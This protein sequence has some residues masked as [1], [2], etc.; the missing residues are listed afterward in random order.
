MA[1]SF[2]EKL[3]QKTN[4]HLLS[5]GLGAGEHTGFID[6]GSYALNL[7]ACG[8][9]W[10]GIPNNS[11]VCLA[12]ETS[13]GKTYFTLGII[14]NFLN[15]HPDAGVFY[16]D[17][18]AAV[19]LKMAEN[20][21]IDAERIQIFGPKS[22][23]SFRTKTIE[24]IVKYQELCKEVGET[25]PFMMVLDSLGNLSSEKELEDTAAFGDTKTAE[26]QRNT[27]DM[28]KAGLLKGSF[29]VLRQTMGELK[30]PMIITNHIYA[31]IGG[32]GPQKIMSGGS[33]PSYVADTI[34]FLTKSKAREGD[35][36]DGEIIGSKITVTANKSREGRENAQ[37]Q[38]LL[39]HNTGLDRYY[40]LLDI[41]LEAGVFKQLAKGIELPGGIK[42]ARKE[43]LRN[44]TEIYTQEIL[45]AINDAT[46][47][48]SMFL[49]GTGTEVA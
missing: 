41:A 5:E 4:V 38:V 30:I 25:P 26:K 9:L 34:W 12:G 8:S 29:R 3:A 49:Y 32:Y 45:Q 40:G 17:T 35:D 44:P 10:D 46:Q 19:R 20:R 15:A 39:N 1:K 21:D 2:W 31:N 43:I 22:I 11:F 7:L 18:E 27:K 47:A 14:K 36:S 42:V 28:T 33:G 24:Q 23:E 6:T 48:Q 16:H 37:V 13:T